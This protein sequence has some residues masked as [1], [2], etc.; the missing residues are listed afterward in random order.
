MYIVKIH[1]ILIQWTTPIDGHSNTNESDWEL[2]I[3]IVRMR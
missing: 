1:T 3:E 2:D